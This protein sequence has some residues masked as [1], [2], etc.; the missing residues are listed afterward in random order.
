M[1]QKS[2]SDFEKLSKLISVG[3]KAIK[4]TLDNR[5]DENDVR[6]HRSEANHSVNAST[7]NTHSGEIAEIKRT[8]RD[9]M[10]RDRK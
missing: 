2:D 3:N 9:R 7:F 5:L 10:R 8:I 4:D 1:E 6:L